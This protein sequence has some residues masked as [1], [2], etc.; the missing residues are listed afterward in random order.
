[1]AQPIFAVFG[2]GGG[3]LFLVL[4]AFILMALFAVGLAV[5]AYFAIRAMAKKSDSPPM[6]SGAQAEPAESG[7]KPVTQHA[8]RAGSQFR[9]VNLSGA[10]FENVNLTGARFHNV[11][12]SNM[13]VTAAQLGGA[14]F[15]HIG[16]PPTE[17]GKQERQRPVRF[18][19]MMLCDSTFQKVDLSNTRITDCDLT[20]MTINGILVTEMVAAYQRQQTGFAGS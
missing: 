12:L 7:R 19:E 10:D 6:V 1:M 4:M 5:V 15:K 3:E 2:L 20:G 14:A 18:E 9:D 13:T 16:P 17:D 8:N 11:N